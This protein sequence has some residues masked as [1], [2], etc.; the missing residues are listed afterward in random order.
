MLIGISKD[1]CHFT[2]W[3]VGKYLLV[4]HKKIKIDW[5]KINPFLGEN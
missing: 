5:L 4:M 3:S 1:Y 2:N